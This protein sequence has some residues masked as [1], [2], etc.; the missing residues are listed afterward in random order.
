MYS[1]RYLQL[2]H[3]RHYYFFCE[4]R[5]QGVY[6]IN[7]IYIASCFLNINDIIQVLLGDFVCEEDVV[8]DYKTNNFIILFQFETKEDIPIWIKNHPEYFL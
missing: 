4:D 2:F 6:D 3:T 8:L 7:N 5:V 1:V